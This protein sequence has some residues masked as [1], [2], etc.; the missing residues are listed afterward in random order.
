MHGVPEGA[1]LPGY[2]QGAI[3]WAEAGAI[4]HDPA[5]LAPFMLL[6]DRRLQALLSSDVWGMLHSAW[7]EEPAIPI[8]LQ[9]QRPWSALFTVGAARLRM[10][11]GPEINLGSRLHSI[12]RQLG[13]M[14]TAGELATHLEAVPPH[15]IEGAIREALS[16]VWQAPERLASTYSMWSAQ[17]ASGMFDGLANTP[18]Y[19][20]ATLREAVFLKRNRTW[21]QRLLSAQLPPG[22]FLLMVGAFH[23]VGPGNL[24]ELLREGGCTIRAV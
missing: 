7:H 1:P 11:P 20:S 10:S 17:D 9:S 6:P 15:E 4:E 22:N 21:A 23:L 3:D 18:L 8:D 2:V 24:L 13:V 14:E 19:R 12:G 16:D 5:Q